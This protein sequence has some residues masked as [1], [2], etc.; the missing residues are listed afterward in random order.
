VI[1]QLPRADSAASMIVSTAA[2][3]VTTSIGAPIRRMRLMGPAD[4]S[5]VGYTGVNVVAI[6]GQ[7]LLVWLRD[8][9]SILLEAIHCVTAGSVSTASPPKPRIPMPNPRSG[10]RIRLT[11]SLRERT[12]SLPKAE[13]RWLLTVLSARNS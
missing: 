10:S 4:A 13:E 6:A 7:P 8:Q 12:P 11:A 2:A 5:P 9:V 3:S 1:V